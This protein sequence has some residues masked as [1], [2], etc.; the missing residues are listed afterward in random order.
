L[1]FLFL[2]SCSFPGLR[3]LGFKFSHTLITVRLK[4]GI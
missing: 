1:N 2:L 3:L 4:K